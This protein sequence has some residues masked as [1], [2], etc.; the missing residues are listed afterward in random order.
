MSWIPLAEALAL[1]EQRYGLRLYRNNLTARPVGKSA[2][3]MM[4]ELEAAGLARTVNRG[5]R[6]F[7][8]VSSEALPRLAK[9]AASARPGPPPGAQV[10]LDAE[11]LKAFIHHLARHASPAEH[12]REALQAATGLAHEVER[13]VIPVSPRRPL[14]PGDAQAESQKP[15]SNARA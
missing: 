4:E 2:G 14:A 5:T 15:G 3:S 12:V 10:T 1:V 6:R 13:I 9:L 7:W 8:E 11:Q